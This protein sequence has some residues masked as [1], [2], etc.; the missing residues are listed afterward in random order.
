MWIT[1]AHRAARHKAAHN[2]QEWL[3]YSS[4]RVIIDPEWA[5]A[6]T[7]RAAKIEIGQNKINVIGESA[8]ED[9]LRQRETEPLREEA[10]GQVIE[11]DAQIP[12][13]Q[14]HNP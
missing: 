12:H 7:S 2:N 1:S 9:L 11:A 4:I 14:L 6:K 5:K 3:E 10:R 8:E 13:A